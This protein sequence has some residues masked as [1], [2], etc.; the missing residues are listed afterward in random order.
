MKRNL[1]EIGIAQGKCAFRKHKEMS[2]YDSGIV[3]IRMQDG[4]Y[5]RFATDDIEYAFNMMFYDTDGPED[6][7]LFAD[8]SIERG[9]NAV[10]VYMFDEQGAFLLYVTR[11]VRQVTGARAR[12]GNEVL[13]PSIRREAIVVASLFQVRL[14][15]KLLSMERKTEE[16]SSGTTLL[17]VGIEDGERQF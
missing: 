9:W 5:K 15:D 17:S 8:E 12:Y 10:F 14:V 11:E 16:R 13:Y 7:L 6:E 3:V 1:C 4:A 2:V